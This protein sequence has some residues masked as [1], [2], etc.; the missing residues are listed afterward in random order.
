VPRKGDPVCSG[1]FPRVLPCASVRRRS[2]PKKFSTITTSGG[3]DGEGRYLAQRPRRRGT[4]KMGRARQPASGA[5][6]CFFLKPFFSE[7]HLW[8]MLALSRRAAMKSSRC[9]LWVLCLL[10]VIA[11]LDAIP[12]PP[13][14]KPHFNAF[15]LRLCLA[16]CYEQRLHRSPLGSLRLRLRAFTNGHKPTR[17]CDW[18]VLTGLA[19][20]PSPPVV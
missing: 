3:P 1:G 6:R 20:D 15:C 7:S 4:P 5:T 19:A 16:T 9:A 18:I 10:L 14:V 2:S 11:S 17:P 12:D 8:D 13:A